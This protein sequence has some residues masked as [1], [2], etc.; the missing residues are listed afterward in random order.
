MYIYRNIKTRSFNHCCRGKAM[1]YIF[2][3]S[4][5]SLR[6]PAF[7]AH[8]PYCHLLPVR[9]YNIFP[10]CLINTTNFEKKLLN[11]KCVFRLSLQNLSETF[12]IL[13]RT[14]RDMIIN[15]HWS[16][17]CQNSMRLEVFDRFLENNQYKIS[18]KS[19]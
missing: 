10:R 18:W 4:V 2:W 6:F 5:C 14:E 15:V 19:I 12:L 13:S 17:S 7:N 1:C 8:A 16:Y 3:V 11:K 9:L